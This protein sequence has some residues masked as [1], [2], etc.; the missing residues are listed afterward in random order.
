MSQIHAV[1]I[2]LVIFKL[3]ACLREDHS[4]SLSDLPL[5][6]MAFCP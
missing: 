1:A 6:I 4:E 5:K 2:Q 3:P